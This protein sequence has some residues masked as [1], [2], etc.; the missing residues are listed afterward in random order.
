MHNAKDEGIKRVNNIPQTI[1]C[2]IQYESASDAWGDS[3]YHDYIELLYSLEGSCEIMVEGH[4]THLPQGGM[5]IIQA[6]ESHGFICPEG[7]QTRLC[8]KFLPQVL[9][10]SEQTVTELEYSIPYVFEHFGEQRLFSPEELE[11]TFIPEAIADICE[12]KLAGRFGYELALRSQVQRIFLWIIRCWHQKEGSRDFADNSGAAALLCR[13]KEYV[14]DNLATATM[15]TA[16]Q[17]CGLSYGYFSRLFNAHM[18][19]SFSA[20]VNR[21]R[22]ARSLQLLATTGM[23]VTEIAMAVGFSSTSYYIQ[24]FR[25]DK[26][27]S[28]NQFRKLSRHGGEN[29]G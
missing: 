28:P 9:Y 5:F 6:G 15:A 7:R 27:L 26:G 14:K 29:A 21:E 8:I 10:S 24:V 20:Y 17:V 19:M 23:S 2:L 18:K 13:A 3:H 12:E 11:G 25:K 22:V 1:E 16:A 4:A